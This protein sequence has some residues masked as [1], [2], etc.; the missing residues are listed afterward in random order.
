VIGNQIQQISKGTYLDREEIERMGMSMEVL[1]PKI[2]LKAQKDVVTTVVDSTTKTSTTETKYRKAYI[3]P[4]GRN[5]RR[6]IPSHSDNIAN[7]T[8]DKTTKTS[9][10]ETKSPQVSQSM[11]IP[12]QGRNLRRNISRVEIFDYTEADGNMI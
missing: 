1:V 7:A 3:P 11:Y 9:T 8:V 6:N 2:E 10:S 12:P 4:Q 5:P